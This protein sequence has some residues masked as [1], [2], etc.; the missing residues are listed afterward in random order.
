MKNKKASQSTKYKYSFL[1]LILSL[2]AVIAT[3]L[4]GVTKGLIVSQLYE[5][6]NP[7]AINR[8]LLISIGVVV[9]GLALYAILEPKATSNFITRRQTRYGSNLLIMSIA[10]LGILIVGNLL[11]YQNPVLVA[12]LTADKQNTLP[13]ELVDAVHALPEKIT[14]VAFFSSQSNKTNA[15]D[16]LNNIKSNSNGKFEYSFVDPDQN[17]LVAHN[18]GITGDGKILLTMGD[19]KE[20]A[21]SADNQEI[22]KAIIRLTNPNPRVV[23]FLTGN[24]EHGLDQ[25]DP[26]FSTAKQ[27]LENKNYT[28][29]P[30]NLI[31]DGKVPEDAQ[32]IVIGGPQKPLTDKEVE[33]L[34]AYVD[35]GGSLVVMEDPVPLTQ[36]GDAPDP[37]ADYLANDWGITLDKDVIIDISNSYGPLY[38]VSAIANQHP[39]TQ[40]INQ[41]LIIIMP[42]AR[43]ISLTSQPANVTQTALIETAP[44]T[45][46]SVNSWGETNLDPSQGSQ[47][48]F[49][50]GTDIVGPLSMATAGENTTTKGRVVVMG[51]STF[52]TGKN[53][54]V[55]GNGN[56]F[57]NSVDWAAEQEDLI[58]YTPAQTTQ[59]TFTPPSQIGWLSILLGLICIIPGLIIL[60]GVSTWLSRRRQG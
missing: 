14:A 6:S 13:K 42:Q 7:D 30:L 36:F 9:L 35:N 49:D 1:A 25:G 28:I 19:R 23:Y 32:A 56:F 40:D 2:V 44:P 43:S 57:V 11:G 3:L 20:I 29:K 18:A 59:R 12:D 22:L 24:G 8:W 52:A 41:N 38:A 50:Q 53:F 16:L 26:N 27:T 46:T 45:Q 15:E 47:V 17:P 4:L 34:K 54:D 60:A 39:I 51:S 37:L 10:F 5:V 33:L 55:N 48:Q 58:K 21:A 31:A